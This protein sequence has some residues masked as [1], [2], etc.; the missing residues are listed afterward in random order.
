[1]AHVWAS[2][3]RRGDK[4]CVRGRWREVKEVRPERRGGGNPVVVLLFKDGPAQRMNATA[5]V[6]M[7]RGGKGVR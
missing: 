7:V 1:M 2:R 5:R 3:V 4:V 6:E